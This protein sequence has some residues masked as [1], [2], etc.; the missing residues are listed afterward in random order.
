MVYPRPN[1]NNEH[2]VTIDQLF[3]LASLVVKGKFPDETY[4]E[5]EMDAWGI[6]NRIVKY[7]GTF[8]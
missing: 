6:L 8:E 5:E 2:V 3:H 4:S 1:R 7:P